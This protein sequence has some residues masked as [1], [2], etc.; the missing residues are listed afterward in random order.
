[1]KAGQNDAPLGVFTNGD[2]TAIAGG[3]R[4][5]EEQIAEMLV[6]DLGKISQ[7][8]HRVYSELNPGTYLDIGCFQLPV[9]VQ[10]HLAKAG[11][12]AHGVSLWSAEASRAGAI[13]IVLGGTIEF[14]EQDLRGAR[15]DTYRLRNKVSPL[16]DNALM[17]KIE[18]YPSP[19]YCSVHWG[20]MCPSYRIYP[21]RTGHRRVWKRCNPERTS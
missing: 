21:H 15:N 2:S 5:W 18:S 4:F 16:N 14:F 6:V 11:S 13:A 9:L 8:H 12:R 20:L 7:T 3:G 1:M 19:A 17:T 10:I